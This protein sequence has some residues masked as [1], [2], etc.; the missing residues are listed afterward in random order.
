M[1]GWPQ[2]RFIF[3]FNTDLILHTS[4]GTKRD[5]SLVVM[6]FFLHV[7]CKLKL[8]TYCLNLEPLW[9][10]LQDRTM[11]VILFDKQSVHALTPCKYSSVDPLKSSFQYK[12]QC[13]GVIGYLVAYHLP[14]TGVLMQ[15]RAKL[16]Y[17]L[18]QHDL[19]SLKLRLLK[20]LT[21]ILY[22]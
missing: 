20:S 5:I 19:E 8:H 6:S 11:Q 1:Y 3:L 13:T 22:L 18:H 2:M 16:K 12:K 7:R 14:I 17:L 10:Y 15:I 21:K 4:K 9:P